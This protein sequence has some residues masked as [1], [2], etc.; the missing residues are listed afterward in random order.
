MSSS[1]SVSFPGLWLELPNPN[2][3][4]LSKNENQITQN[5]SKYNANKSMYVE[6]DRETIPP[7]NSDPAMTRRFED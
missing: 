4:Q 5:I 1:G 3:A 6:R 7:T 2:F